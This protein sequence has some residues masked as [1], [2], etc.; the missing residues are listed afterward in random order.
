MKYKINKQLILEVNPI[1]I[2]SKTDRMLNDGEQEDILVP[3]TVLALGALGA[4]KTYDYIKEPKKNKDYPLNAAL[5]LGSLGAGGTL[6]YQTL[7]H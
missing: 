2:P 6:A 3:A 7:P 5:T 4:S 1:F